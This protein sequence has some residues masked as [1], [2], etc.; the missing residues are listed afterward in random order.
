MNALEKWFMQR[1]RKILMVILWVIGAYLFFKYLLSYTAPFIVAWIIAS[2]LQPIVRWLD[3][4][5]KMQRG[6]AT[7]L[8]MVTVLSAISW[9]L[10]RILRKI[11]IQANILYQKIPLFR[12]QILD[13]F[14]VISDKT[15]N[16][17]S[18][19][20]INSTISFEQT[21]DQLFQTVA[22]FLGSFL[23]KGSINIVSK[24][25]NF[26]FFTIITLLSIFFMTRDYVE[27]Q[28]FIK[29]QVPANMTQRMSL[30][31]KD[32]VGALWG[33]IR[34]QLILMCF[35]MTIC[36]VGFL[37]FRINNAIILAVVVAIVDALPMFGSG[38]FLIPWA[39]YNVI[40]GQ[41]SMALGL[42]G[43][44]AFIIVI[45]QTMEPRVLSNQIG[46]YTLVTLI[47]MYIGFKVLGVLGLII[48]PII[49]IVI[50]TLQKVGLLPAFKEVK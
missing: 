18:A 35:T 1:G 45:R 4:K 14:N 47:A 19:L 9:G 22:S 21:V 5:L 20:P 15:R 26:L 32:L 42:G 44:Y 28:K 11:F 17:F 12:D 36:I 33:Y 41:Y 24:V 46:V 37:I 43:I 16:I 27:I 6:I 23:S 7:V 50:Q 25:P 10:T 8:S 29:A 39:L 34:T 31:K 38:A 13:T 3:E 40:I 48:G 49:I 30:L 2:I